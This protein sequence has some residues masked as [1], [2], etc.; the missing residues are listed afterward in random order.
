MIKLYWKDG[1]VSELPDWVDKK[2]YLS[3]GFSLENPIK[4]KE[5][6]LDLVDE[7]A[8]TIKKTKKEKV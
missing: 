4:E 6:Q 7:A 2:Y 3:K 1:K 5:V 8:A